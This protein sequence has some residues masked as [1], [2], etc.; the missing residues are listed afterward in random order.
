M[1][2]IVINLLTMLLN[3]EPA[4]VI[5]EECVTEIVQD[6]S[7]EI[8][9]NQTIFTDMRTNDNVQIIEYDGENNIYIG[10]RIWDKK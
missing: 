2:C 8:E 5:R 4:T 6:M 9:R 10:E 3:G 1:E 7:G